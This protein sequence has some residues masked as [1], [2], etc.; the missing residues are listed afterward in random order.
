MNQNTIPSKKKCQNLGLCFSWIGQKQSVTQ[1][2]KIYGNPIMPSNRGTKQMNQYWNYQFAPGIKIIP[3]MQ[4]TTSIS[5]LFFRSPSVGLDRFYCLSK[6]FNKFDQQRGKQFCLTKK[7]Q[8]LKNTIAI[9]TRSENNSFLKY[10]SGGI[11]VHK[12]ERLWTAARQ[13]QYSSAPAMPFLPAP[14]NFD[15]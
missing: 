7:F 9:F 12:I 4:P 10:I 6:V 11:Q 3:T 15:R 14:V 8:I 1:N 5:Q 2:T 13:S